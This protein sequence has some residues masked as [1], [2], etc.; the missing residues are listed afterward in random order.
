MKDQNEQ[1][2]IVE[3]AYDLLVETVRVHFPDMG[4]PGKAVLPKVNG[5]FTITIEDPRLDTVSNFMQECHNRLLNQQFPRL[6][7]FR[8]TFLF[9]GTWRLPT[10]ESS[11]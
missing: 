3:R 4:D 10:Q 7:Q 1:N 8:L 11:S 6:E 2:E 5:D 9:E